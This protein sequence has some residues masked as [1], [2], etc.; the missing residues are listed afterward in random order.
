MTTIKNIEID[1]SSYNCPICLEIFDTP[2]S[3]GCGHTFCKPCISKV[4]KKSPKCPSCQF[5]MCCIPKRN[6]LINDIIMKLYPEH[7]KLEKITSDIINIIA[8]TEYKKYVRI[9]MTI[10]KSRID[11][12]G[13]C[14]VNDIIMDP[15]MNHVMMGSNLGTLMKSYRTFM[16]NDD[17]YI[18]KVTSKG[19]REEIAKLVRKN[20][21]IFRNTESVIKIFNE[22]VDSF[23]CAEN[24]LKH[25][26]KKYISQSPNICDKYN[27]LYEQLKT[28]ISIK[29]ANANP[30][31]ISGMLND[32]DNSKEDSSLTEGETD[33]SEEQR[34]EEDSDESN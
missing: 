1:I 28:D 14:N 32:S 5:R 4:I 26:V 29:N 16:V 33:S 21:D 17:I 20:P 23:T 6:V 31:D 34:E 3:V 30:I 2:V 24:S 8:S 22:S 18:Y 13:I 9:Q 19:G 10:L 25:I 15:L 12:T 27:T 11:K 7:A